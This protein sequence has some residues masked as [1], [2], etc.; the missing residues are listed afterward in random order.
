[1]ARAKLTD[2]L[3]GNTIDSVKFTLRDESKNRNY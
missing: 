2:L 1:M 3:Y